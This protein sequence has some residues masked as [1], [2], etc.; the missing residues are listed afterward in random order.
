MDA[1]SWLEATE[2]WGRAMV[3]VLDAL[4]AWQAGGRARAATLLAASR[5]LQGRSRAVRADPPRNRWGA[6]PV[7]VGDGVVDVFLAEAAARV[8]S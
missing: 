5:E 6:A 7:R 3:S 8:E 2:G 4:H 1:A